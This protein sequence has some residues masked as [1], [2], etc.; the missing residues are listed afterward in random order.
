ML[1]GSHSSLASSQGR[2]FGTA[3]VIFLASMVALDFA[4]GWVAKPLMHAVDLGGLVKFEMIPPVML[5]LLA[6]LTL[7]RFGTLIA[8]EGAWGIIALVAMPGAVLPGPLK[9]VPLLLQGCFLDAAFS[10]FRRWG[11]A[12]VFLAAVFGGLAGN[13]CLMLFRVLLG[14]P[15]ARATQVFFGLQLL[16]GIGIHLAGAALAVLVWNRVRS[17]EA[18]RWI[19]VA[20]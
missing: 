4:F 12:R 17:Q 14:M 9:L 11:V 7:D 1:P 8:Y 5:M 10:A 19:Q 6:R 20:P 18:V 15:W 2:R 13:A 16:G 3:Q